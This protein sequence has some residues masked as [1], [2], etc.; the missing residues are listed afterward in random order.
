MG[1]PYSKFFWGD[2]LN[3]TR[4]LSLEAKGAWM[5]VLCYIA[6]SDTP[7]EVGY[8]IESWARLLGCGKAK[9]KRIFSEINEQK[10]GEIFEKNGKIYAKNNRILDDYHDYIKRI[11]DASAAGKRSSKIKRKLLQ[12]KG[13]IATSVDTTVDTTVEDSLSNSFNDHPNGS[14]TNQKPVPEAITRNSL[15]L[16]REEQER[17]N[18]LDQELSENAVTN[19]SSV[20]EAPTLD[21]VKQEA[22]MR[23][24]P[25]EHATSFFEYNEGQQLWINRN[26][27]PI[28]WRMSLKSWSERRRTM[29]PGQANGKIGYKKIEI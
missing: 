22:E 21:E 6:D 11:S 9:L 19:G 12:I 15:S 16:T 4:V 26:G 1:L 27:K 23:G 8:K 3:A 10:V 17:E 24:I 14:A 18:R 2:Y 20:A 25:R 7:G 5:D 29:K 28:N 13:T